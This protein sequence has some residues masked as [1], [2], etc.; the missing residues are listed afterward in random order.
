MQKKI[1]PIVKK[2]LHHVSICNSRMYITFEVKRKCFPFNTE[3]P[4]F[5]C[6]FITINI[7]NINTFSLHFWVFLFEQ[8]LILQFKY[9]FVLP[10]LN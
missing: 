3:P 5:N 1:K 6:F 8:S 4:G 9:N 2:Y 10:E 7:L